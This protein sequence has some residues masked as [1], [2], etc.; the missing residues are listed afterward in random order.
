MLKK[1]SGII[2]IISCCF[3]VVCFKMSG[4]M[5]DNNITQ[6]VANSGKYTL[7]TDYEYPAIYD[8]NFKKLNNTQKKYYAVVMPEANS[9]M[10][11]LPYAVDKKSL[12]NR[13]ENKMPFLCEVN[14]EGLNNPEL[15]VFSST[16][17]TNDSML[18]PHIVGY[19]S[20]GIGICGVERAFGEYI[21]SIKTRNKITYNVDA[22]GG[23]LD[24]TTYKLEKSSEIKAGVVTT[25]DSDIQQICE[26]AAK[27]INRGAVLVMDVNTGEIKACVSK[28]D[29]NPSNV[30]IYLDD[31]DSPMI[32]RAFSAYNVGSIFKLVIAASALESGISPEYT[33]TCTGKISIKDVEFSCHKWDGHQEIDMCTAM[34]ES[35]NT[36]FINLSTFISNDKILEIS[37]SF[38]FGNNSLLCSGMI[39]QAGNVQNM[40]ELQIPAEKANMSFGQGKLTATPLQVTLLTATIANGGKTPAPVL[41]SGIFDKQGEFLPYSNYKSHRSISEQTA[42]QLQN[43]M[44]KTVQVDNSRSKPLLTSAGGKTSTAQTGKFNGNNIEQSTCWFTG[45]FPV[46]NPK[47][48]VTVVVEDGITGNISCG[49]VFKEIADN[50]TK[51]KK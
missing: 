38:G 36:Y 26:T 1:L 17:R 18:A 50:I 30:S 41:I 29:F 49:P 11:V 13:L 7:Y 28:P 32:N 15:I 39:S 37:K 46:D 6:A 51:E 45:F 8:C 24:G 34:A 22:V 47:Y 35:C 9:V 44:V 20:D 10:S 5:A 42:E 31:A 16:V 21:S 25:I 33:Y 48:A 40:S 19:C 14:T 43:F 12:L 2:I 23:I 4:I 3:A 27:G